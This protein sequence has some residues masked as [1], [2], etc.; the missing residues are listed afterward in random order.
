M[1]RLSLLSLLALCAVSFTLGTISAKSEK[2]GYEKG[3]ETYRCGHCKA[4]LEHKDAKCHTHGCPGAT[5]I[6]EKQVL[7]T[8]EERRAC[9]E[10]CT[11]EC[12]E[13]TEKRGDGEET[14]CIRRTVHEKCEK[15]IKHRVID[16]KQ[17]CPAGTTMKPGSEREN[18]AHHKPKAKK[19]KAAEAA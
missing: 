10:T 15:P 7:V 14:K 1:K 17:A 3:T 9:E 13:G 4:H 19:V 2:G 6:C 16:C 18:G 11:F 5:V 8:E 12:P